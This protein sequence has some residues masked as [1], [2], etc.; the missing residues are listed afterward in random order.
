MSD[1]Y[2][3]CVDLLAKGTPTA[4]MGGTGTICIY[5]AQKVC[6]TEPHTGSAG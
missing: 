4:G 3:P 5:E 1:L 2:A 6:S